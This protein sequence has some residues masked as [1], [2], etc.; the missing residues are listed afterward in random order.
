MEVRHTL[1]LVKALVVY[2]DYKPPDVDGVFTWQVRA[3]QPVE[4]SKPGPHAHT[5]ALQEF[6]ATGDGVPTSQ[7]DEMI[8]KQQPEECCTLIYTSGTTGPPKGVMLSHD[9]ITWTAKAVLDLFAADETDHLVSY[10]PLSH[11]AAAMI[12]MYGE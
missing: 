8:A 9:N 7:V 12:D 11:I 1:P 10:L 4:P 6:L 2:N 3:L 5:C